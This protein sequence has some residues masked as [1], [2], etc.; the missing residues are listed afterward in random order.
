M[1]YSPSTLVQSILVLV[2]RLV[3]GVVLFAHGWQKLVTNGLAGTTASFENMGVPFAP[4]S[5]VCA[6][7]VELVGGALLIAGAGTLI[8]G[9]LVALDMLGAVSV[10]HL[11]NGVFVQHG[12]WELAGVILAASILLV[13]VGAGRFSVDYAIGSRRTPARAGRVPGGQDLRADRRL[14]T[15]APRGRYA[16]NAPSAMPTSPNSNTRQDKENDHV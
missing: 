4:V 11:G 10:V 13:A 16:G 3:L 15:R 14:S 7:F 9:V 12:G 8:V 5:S 2:G 1:T 6:T